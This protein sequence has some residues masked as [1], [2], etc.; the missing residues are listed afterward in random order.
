MQSFTA[1]RNSRKLKWKK[2]KMTSLLKCLSFGVLRR[3]SK[4]NYSALGR[5]S[6]KTSSL[7]VKSVIVW[8]NS[9]VLTRVQ[10]CRPYRKGNIGGNSACFRGEKELSPEV[11]V[12]KA[13]IYQGQAEV[14]KMI[15]LKSEKRMTPLHPAWPHVHTHTLTDSFLHKVPPQFF[16]RLLLWSLNLQQKRVV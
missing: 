13:E 7:V 10:K 2:T 15:S 3:Y 9:T 11:W 16:L 8:E 5:N 1:N 12:T 14:G 4:Y 6:K